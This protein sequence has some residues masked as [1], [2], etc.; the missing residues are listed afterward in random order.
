[1]SLTS[2]FRIPA[3]HRRRRFLRLS[4]RFALV[5][6]VENW[7]RALVDHLG[8]T[9]TDYVCRLRN[10]LR[11]HVRGGTDDRHII[12]EVFAEGIYPVELSEGSVVVD[13]GAQIGCFSLLAAQRGAH[14]VSFE[15][16]PANFAALQRNLDLN[17]ATRVLPFQAAVTG[18]R[19]TRAM[20]LPDDGRHTGRFSLHPGRGTRTVEAPCVP[21]EDILTEH[22]LDRIDLIKLDCQGSEYEI[23][24]GADVK[25]FDRI[26][27]MV[28][29]CEVFDTP[30]TGPL[31]PCSGTLKPSDFR[32]SLKE[33]LVCRAS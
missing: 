8:L 23:L 15:P 26:R 16:F 12:F 21:L 17:R 32:P 29:E 13:V 7:P 24:Y 33:H 20:L 18:K 28:V 6:A 27:A 25:I 10:G 4:K 11:F 19:E 1:M 3:G 14:V 31:P 9:Q 22:R 30:R 5:A 2:S